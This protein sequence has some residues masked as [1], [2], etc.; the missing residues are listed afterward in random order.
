[1]WYL[2][3]LIVSYDT[4]I[5]FSNCVT[6]HHSLWPLCSKQFYMNSLRT[7]LSENSMS[8]ININPQITGYFIIFHGVLGALYI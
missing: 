6:H 3:I 4:Y 7:G 1:M 8:Q 5:Y 2:G